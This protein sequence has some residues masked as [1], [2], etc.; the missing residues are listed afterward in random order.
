MRYLNVRGI[1]LPLCN[2]DLDDLF[3]KKII[4][5][6]GVDHDLHYDP[7]MPRNGDDID[8]LLLAIDRGY[9]QRM[10]T[11][12]AETFGKY[13]KNLDISYQIDRAKVQDAPGA[14]AFLDML[15]FTT[16]HMVH[17][18]AEEMMKR[19]LIELHSW[20][21]ERDNLKLRLNIRAMPVGAHDQLLFL[22]EQIEK[23][24]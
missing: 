21:D 12:L 15:D 2:D 5:D 16:K 13:V 6:C 4:Y 17:D 18:L 9:R 3:A 20:T 8:D 14:G 23:Q 7:E 22:L 24:V 1:D 19:G 11:V 10:S